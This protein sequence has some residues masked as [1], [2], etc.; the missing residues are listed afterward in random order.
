MKRVTAA[1]LGVAFGFVLS[2][3]QLT[4]PDRIRSMLLLEDTYYYLMMATAVVI[5]T[6][7]VRALRR[8]RTVTASPLA[9]RHVTGSVLFGIGWAVTNACPGPIAA[10]I[11]QGTAW[12]LV[13]LA[14]FF[15][16]ARL[17]AAGERRRAALLVPLAGLV[18]ALL[19]VAPAGAAP[20]KQ[21]V[22]VPGQSLGGLR[23][24][25]T[26]AQVAAAW[27]PRHGSCRDCREETWYFN[28]TPFQPQGA[29]VSFRKGRVAALFT[30]WKPEGWRTRSGL[31][32]ADP[33]PLLFALHDGLRRTDCGPYDAQVLRRESTDTVFYVYDDEIWGFGL[34]TA[35]VDPCR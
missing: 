10:Q 11:G 26:K 5:G 3:T 35:G 34:T 15:L 18:A 21:G 30:L 17:H 12:A 20:P 31:R 13:T 8:R 27:G 1:L 2:W 25:A 32:L 6:V 33:D 24:G 7:G 19:V 22:L 4:S 28:Y 14:G 23:L 29:G 9:R 16:G